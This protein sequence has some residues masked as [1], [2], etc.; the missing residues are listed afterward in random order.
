MASSHSSVTPINSLVTIKLIKDNYLI[1]KTQ[2]VPY[3]Y[4]Q[5]M[6]EF[7]DG[8]ISY[9]S[10]TIPNPETTTSQTTP[11]E[12]SNLNYITWT[13]Q[14]QVVLSALASSLLEN[15]LAHMVGL[16]TSRE[17]W[18]AL[19]KMFTSHSSTR[20]IQTRQLFASTKKGNLS[21][22]YYFQKIRSFLNNLAAI[23]QPLQN[24][25]FTAY[26]LGSLDT[27]YDA[28]VTSISTQIDKMT[29]EDMFNHLL[30]FELQLKQQ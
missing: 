3:L 16:L 20:T 24:H 7:I 17:V 5:R 30:A 2:I 10:P 1:W 23:G 27:S 21:I 9:P 4:G 28:I 25:E 18:V 26:L 15:I 12:I 8:T 29:L 19:E 22:F 13:D 14:Y 6:F 11:T